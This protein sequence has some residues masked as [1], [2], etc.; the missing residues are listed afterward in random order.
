[1]LLVAVLVAEVF[2]IKIIIAVDVDY[3][4]CGVQRAMC[5]DETRVESGDFV[6]G[7]ELAVE[8]QQRRTTVH[9][10]HSCSQHCLVLQQTSGS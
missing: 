2:V 3:Y 4:A 7:A 8:S 5:R 6:V 9:D 1:M 10:I